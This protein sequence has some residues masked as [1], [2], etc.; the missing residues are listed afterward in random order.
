MKGLSCGP[1]AKA[2][3]LLFRRRIA[4]PYR[5]SLSC[6]SSSAAQPLNRQRL[7]WAQSRS[8]S[9]AP[10]MEENLSLAQLELDKE[11]KE[12][13]EL[14]YAYSFIWPSFKLYVSNKENLATRARYFQERISKY[15][16]LDRAIICTRKLMLYRLPLRHSNELTLI[17][18]NSTIHCCANISTCLMWTRVFVSLKTYTASCWLPSHR[19]IFT[20]IAWGTWNM[21]KL[22]AE[23]F[24]K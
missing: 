5:Q 21:Y 16:K 15:S 9:Q 4:T 17:L 19:K 20:T 7:Q 24:T 23:G 6:G 1:R 2:A 11:A 12:N 22:A 10:H 3:R 13:R 14:L 8:C 18:Q